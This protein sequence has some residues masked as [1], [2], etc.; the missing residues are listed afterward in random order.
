VNNQASARTKRNVSDPAWRLN[1]PLALS[2]DEVQIWRLDLETLAGAEER[3]QK[4]LSV[5]E[6]ARAKRFVPVKVRQQFVA[7]HGMLR[8]LLAG[9]LGSEARSLIFQ[10]SARGKPSLGPP[11]SNSRVSFNIAHSGA[12]ALLAF[13]RGREIG[14]DVE[15]VRRNLDVEAIARRFFSLAEQEQL[16]AFSAEDKYEAFFRCWTRK[17]AYIKAKG[18]GLALPLDQFDVCVAA[19]ADNALLATRPDSSEAARWSLRD[20]TAGPGYVGALCVVGHDF[21][22]RGW[23]EAE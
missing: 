3:W 4:I 22:V 5:D 18:E 9:Y 13:G 16:A 19:G 23:A 14:V 8:I 20:I 6:Q 2:E 7:T 21:R 1:A 15:Q 10:H 17:E 11:H 12:V